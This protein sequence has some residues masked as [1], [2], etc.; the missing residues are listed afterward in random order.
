MDGALPSVVGG[1]VR[2]PVIAV[3]TS[4]GYGAS[5]RRASRALLD[6]AQQLRRR[7]DRREHRQRLRRGGRRIANHA[8][9]QTAV[10]LPRAAATLC[11]D[12]IRPAVS[13]SN[14]VG[15][16][17]AGHSPASTGRRMVSNVPIRVRPN[18][19]GRR[20]LFAVVG[21]DRHGGVQRQ[22]RAAAPLVRR[23]GSYPSRTAS[24]KATS[25]V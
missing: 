20:S 10:G 17:G 19:I 4:V 1:L 8:R 3:P 14:R 23:S 7:R 9:L 25:F 18:Q 5:L 12:R 15:T 22:R 6:D 13:F 24:S 21:T 16:R 2:A 11:R